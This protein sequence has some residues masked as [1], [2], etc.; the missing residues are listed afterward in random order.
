M[1]SIVI[2]PPDFLFSSVPSSVGSRGSQFRNRPGAP[3]R[4]ES[5]GARG[6]FARLPPPPALIVLAT[7]RAEL[8]TLTA[9]PARL[10]PDARA[11][12]IVSRSPCDDVAR[13]G[14]RGAGGSAVEASLRLPSLPPN[15]EE[16]VSYT[17]LTLP[18]TPYV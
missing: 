9:E 10:T 18:T 16:A 2:H 13:S 8:A 17:H 14:D 7:L 3:G 1:P 12:L 6:G 5:A 15:R 11:R 4:F